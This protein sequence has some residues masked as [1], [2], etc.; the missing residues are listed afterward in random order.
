MKGGRECHGYRQAYSIL[1]NENSYANRLQKRP[2]GPRVLS[3]SKPYPLTVHLSRD[4]QS[5]AVTHFVHCHLAPESENSLTNGPPRD[6]VLSKWDSCMILELALSTIAL[7]LF[8]NSKNCSR[9]ASLALNS[10]QKS[11]KS[12]RIALS[13]ES[14]D[15]DACLLA[16]C[17]L[18]KYEDA[19]YN[20]EPRSDALPSACMRRQSHLSGILALLS[21]WVKKVPDKSQKPSTVIRYAR[22]VLRKAA[23]FNQMQF[24]TWLENGD[25]FGEQ[26]S[27]LQLDHLL[28]RLIRV[29]DQLNLFRHGTFGS[30]Y[31]KHIPSL[32]GI[33]REATSIDE[34]LHFSKIQ[35]TI[36]SHNAK[37]TLAVNRGYCKDYFLLPQ[38]Y[39]CRD[40]EQIAHAALYCGYRIAAND[41]CI[42]TIKLLNQCLQDPLQSPLLG[43]QQIM[44][45]QLAELA[46]LT[47]S[48]LDTI[49]ITE[50][51]GSFNDHISIRR[52]EERKLFIAELMAMPMLIASSLDS[53]NERYSNWFRSQLGDTGRLLGYRI[54]QAVSSG[55]YQG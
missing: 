47:P 52:E 2:R 21:Y 32:Q 10:Y 46:S 12:L 16:V 55:N 18:G 48:G 34:A 1:N 35:N 44:D 51:P 42:S 39:A 28:I 49:E 33:I 17:F 50:D 19:V 37:C 22:R 36:L 7:A 40:Y 4:L 23:I 38:V 3:E 14:F 11:L 29:H 13:L 53:V 41:L 25:R 6:T 8:S 15:F 5:E 20:P 9:T 27:M 26:G 24:P 54:M 43:C 30:D 45:D 31:A